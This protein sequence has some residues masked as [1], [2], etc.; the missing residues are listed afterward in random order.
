MT[1][2]AG[3]LFEAPA[4]TGPF[5]AS[6]NYNFLTQEGHLAFPRL[7]GELYTGDPDLVLITHQQVNG[8]SIYAGLVKRAVLGADGVLRA[9]WWDANDVLK[10]QPLAVT[11]APA[12]APARS[13]QTACVGS[14]M[15]SG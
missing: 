14:C 4:A 5:T 15:S 2:D 10:G 3:H 13:L 11:P 8:K 1:F 7:W 12:P 6:R 9:Q